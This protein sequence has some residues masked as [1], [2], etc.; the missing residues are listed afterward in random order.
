[1]KVRVIIV[2][3]AMGQDYNSVELASNSLFVHPRIIYQSGA[4]MK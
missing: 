3:V 4:A 1:M 2:I